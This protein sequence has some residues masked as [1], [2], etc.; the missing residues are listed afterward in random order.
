MTSRP[1]GR[2]GPPMATG[3]ML[4]GLLTLLGL[5][6]TGRAGVGPFAF[7]S[8]PSTTNQPSKVSTTTEPSVPVTATPV[9]A[10][11]NQTSTA[12]AGV[13][14][15]TTST[16]I[17]E[18]QGAFSNGDCVD[19]DPRE[20]SAAGSTVACSQPHTWE[21]TGVYQMP[22][23]SGAQYPDDGRWNSLDSTGP[24]HALTESY[25]EARGHRLDANGRTLANGKFGVS[26]RQPTRDLWESKQQDSRQVTCYLAQPPTTPGG[27]PTK[28][29]GSVIEQL[30]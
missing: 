22:D 20:P 29:S 15:T 25:L 7:I 26:H 2:H 3:V 13:V 5:V 9:T 6:V 16:T 23:P 14:T 24:C 28:T 18:V 17:Q 10:S 12:V 1:F 30:R 11:V 4:L 21:V 8:Q 19:F 27:V